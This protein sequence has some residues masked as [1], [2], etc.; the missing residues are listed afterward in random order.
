[1]RA[2]ARIVAGAIAMTIS[3]AI[4]MTGANLA[5][6][7]TSPKAE[8]GKTLFHARCGYCHLEGG[9]GTIMLGRRLGK[10][11][12]LLENRTDLSA[13]YIAHVVRAG[14]GSMPRHTRIELP[15]SELDSIAAY[16]TR[17]AAARDATK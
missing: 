10:D 14:I 11:R 2:W 9:T 1:M 6:R 4:S 12:A 7:D 5:A 3:M 16:L 8:D 13:D 15:D 17:P